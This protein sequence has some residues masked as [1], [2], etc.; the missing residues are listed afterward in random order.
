[1]D[2]DGRCTVC[3]EHCNWDE[4]KNN[5][6]YWET[7]VE[8]KEKT[9]DELR[10]RYNI[11]KENVSTSENM[12]A[13]H[14]QILEGLHKKFL[15]MLM[16]IQKK[17]KRLDEIALRPNPL[18]LVKYIELLI[19]SEE[20]E[21]QLGWAERVKHLKIAV[22]TAKIIENLRDPYFD[23]WAEFEESKIKEYGFGEWQAIKIQINKLFGGSV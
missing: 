16:D 19:T 5:P 20:R 22:Q 8:K 4:H 14:K 18:T 2:P 9:D 15:A 3:P 10:S 23:P 12:I 17:L 21:A 13:S 1:M 6:F 11:L 7:V